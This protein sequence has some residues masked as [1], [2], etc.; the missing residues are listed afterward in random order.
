MAGALRLLEEHPDLAFAGLYEAVHQGHTK[1]ARLLLERGADPTKPWRWS[2]WLTPFMHSL[3]HSR[4]NYEM[5]SLLMDHGVTA[6]DANGMGM[7]TLHILVG[8]G[9]PGAVAWL[10]DRGGDIDRRDHEFDSTPLAWA[11]RVGRAEM[12]E[13]LLARGASRTLPDDEPWSTPAAWAS[14]RGHTIILRM[15]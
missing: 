8:L 2:C 3:K 13:L 11:A 7:T 10:L 6:D 4:P 15:L 1:L 14:R 9:T 12:I 5:A